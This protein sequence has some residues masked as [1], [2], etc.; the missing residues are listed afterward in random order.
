MFLRLY[1]VRNSCVRWY[2]ANSYNTTNRSFLKVKPTSKSYLFSTTPTKLLRGRYKNNKNIQSLEPHFEGLVVESEHVELS[3]LWKPFLFTIA[4]S[5]SSLVC[6]AIWQY[7][8]LRARGKLGYHN[9]TRWLQ[10][11]TKKVGKWRNDFNRWYSR[12]SESE[13]VF[14][15]ICLLNVLVFLAWRVPKFQPTMVKYF[16]SN[17]AGSA[18]C[19]PMVLC[20]FSHYSALHLFTNM[21]VLHSFSSGTITNM[22]KEQ[23]VGFYMTAGVI[24]SF[25]SSLHKVVV[26]RPGLSLGASGAIMAVL[27]YMCTRYPEQE[28]SIIFLPFLTFKAATAIKV[29]M[30]I[31]L[32]GILMGWKFVDHAA[33]LGGATFG[34]FWSHWGT[35]HI[36][37][38]RE[39]LLQYWHS[40]RGPPQK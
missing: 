16:C 33:H 29:I 30:G 13:K 18:L 37:Q 6:A 5:S 32:F 26:N 1:S 9:S 31:D 7:E 27:G 14:I 39:P 24:S 23:F 36:W 21:Y 11:T 2:C 22:G 38:K 40:I 8:N 28:L 17:P 15:P 10:G 12:L 4:F 20:T 19:W 25:I 34:I 3:R 35:Y